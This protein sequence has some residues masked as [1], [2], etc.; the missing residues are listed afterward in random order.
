MAEAPVRRVGD[1]SDQQ[2]PRPDVT[3]TDHE[4]ASRFEAHV[5]G[6]GGQGGEPAGFAAYEIDGHAIVFTHTEV[7][8]AHEGQGVGSAL[9]RGALDILRERG[10]L[11]VVPRCSFIK[12]WIDDHPDYADLLSP[13][14]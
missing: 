4:A 14:L 5:E 2:A 13:P 1:M 7:D 12:G 8:P 6:D 3:V 10:G 9:A 11:R